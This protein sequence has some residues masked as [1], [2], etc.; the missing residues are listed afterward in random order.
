M[1]NQS[2]TM[3]RLDSEIVF[4]FQHLDVN[5]MIGDFCTQ[6][7]FEAKEKGIT[8]LNTFW[9]SPLFVQADATELALALAELGRNTVLYTPPNGVITIRVWQQED[10]AV[11]D[12]AD[13]GIGIP[14]ADLPYIFQPLYRVD[15]GRSLE[16]GGGGLGLSIAK[17][18]IE[19]HKG[20][21]VVES[22]VGEGS[23]FRVFLPL[24][25]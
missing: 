24:C 20:H 25:E 12:V 5:A 1:I 4:E 18:I 19:L 7:R 3:V 15:K 9:S 23:L 22:V 16:T 8:V 17:R 6:V 14:E 10:Q 13:T 21:I 11:I 2:L